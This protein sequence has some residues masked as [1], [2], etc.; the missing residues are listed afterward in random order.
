MNIK[1]ILKGPVKRLIIYLIIGM[2][3]LFFLGYI[4]GR[5]I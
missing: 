4:I 3:G 1:S 5:F 2:I